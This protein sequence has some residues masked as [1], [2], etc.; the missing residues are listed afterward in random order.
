V[1]K[2][3]VAIPFIPN[4]PQAQ[5][6][7]TMTGRDIVLKAR[8]MGFSAI[9]LA[10]FATDFILE[11]NSRS[12]VIAHENG[13]TQR[14]FDRVKY[15]IKSFEEKTGA[16]IPL[17][18]NSRS[19]LVNSSNN[20]TFYVGTAGS[21][22]FGRGDTIFN[23]HGSEVAFWPNP[24]TTLTGLLQAVTQGGKVFLESTANGYGNY[25]HTLWD[26]AER[27]ESAFSAHFYPYT[28]L[29]EYQ[30]DGWK[31]A[32]MAEFA[33]PRLF[34]QEFPET[35]EEAF[36]SSGSPFFDVSIIRQWLKDAQSPIKTGSLTMEG[37]WL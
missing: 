8:Q 25:F 29:A 22:A 34:A 32:K 35:A 6:L 24:E 37:V 5:L 1:D 16:K 2:H 33:D 30:V 36:L 7:D 17:K 3:Q 27:K 28:D 11:E 19:E 26:K 21:E 12:V 31:E 15:F 23:L 13:A 18:Y 9:I 4:G 14:L 10:M 20:A